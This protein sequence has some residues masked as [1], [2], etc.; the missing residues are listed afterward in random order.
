[1]RI[2][3]PTERKSSTEKKPRTDPRCLKIAKPNMRV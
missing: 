2:R 1:M 3:S